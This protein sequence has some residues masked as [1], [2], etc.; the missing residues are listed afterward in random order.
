MSI[1]A[2]VNYFN[3]YKGGCDVFVETGT[4]RGA[5]VTLAVLAGF[6]EIHTIDIKDQL[7]SGYRH[8]VR[9][10][11]YHIG[12]SAKILSEILPKLRGR[13]IMF[14]LDAHSQGF[15]GEEENFPL[16]RELREI[17]K[18]EEDDIIL[19]DDFIYLSH[20]DVTGFSRELIER[21]IPKRY[22]ITYLPNP[23]K[24]NILLAK[25]W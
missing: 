14:W 24:N 17:Y 6:Q 15:E 11:F 21:A 20:P 4:Y 3:D 16:L 2:G 1:P 23:I 8:G 25:K 9:E 18:R 10:I 19:I 7:P 12:D 22:R 13:K 5:G